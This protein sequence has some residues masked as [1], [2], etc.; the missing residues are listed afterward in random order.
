MTLWY[1]ALANAAA[2]RV[3]IADYV[4]IANGGGLNR[5][6]IG[7]L[8][9][10][11]LTRQPLDAALRLS[12]AEMPMYAVSNAE[13]KAGV[14]YPL[15][16]WGARRDTPLGQS[17]LSEYLAS[18]GYVVAF[19]NPI[20]VDLP[21]PFETTEAGRKP[22]ILD[23]HVAHLRAALNWLGGQSWIDAS[24]V[25]VVGWSYAGESAVR[26]AME[27]SVRVKLLIGLSASG[28]T[29]A[30]YAGPAS[31]DRIDGKTLRVPVLW[32]EERVKTR[33]DRVT[34]PPVLDKLEQDA[35]SI[36]LGNGVRHG[37][38]HAIEGWLAAKVGVKEVHPW[39][40]SGSQCAR[41]YER[42]ARAVRSGL[43]EYLH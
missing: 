7:K 16:L 10:T 39:S 26:L 32:I 4:E 24:R 29:A 36:R 20:G 23:G 27:E 13:P 17:V 18:H 41:G 8:L 3:R 9:A 28:L 12:T 14:R 38:F 35:R 11:S 34:A 30:P 33:G 43:D 42:A 15:V 1:P 5:D 2:P 6:D 37:C 19:A 22:A 25:A 40:A 31:L 21:P